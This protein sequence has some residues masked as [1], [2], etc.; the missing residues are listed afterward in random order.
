MP[1]SPE[2]RQQAAERMRKLNADPE[3]KARHAKEAAER[4]RK[5]H[6]DPEFKARHAPLA[7]L[8]AQQ[9][10]LYRKLRN[11]GVGRDAALAEVQRATTEPARGRAAANK[12][13]AP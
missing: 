13:E 1:W 3:F 7:Q 10:K 11:N 12:S 2:S 5:L 4:M 8:S 6:A 9:R